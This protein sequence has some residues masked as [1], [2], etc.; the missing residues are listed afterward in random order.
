MSS[1]I[2]SIQFLENAS[3]G[4]NNW[5]RYVLTVIIS[6]IG[7]NL[8]AGLVMVLILTVYSFFL[9]SGGVTNIPNIIMEMISSPFIL[10]VL[11]GISYVLSFFFFYICLRFLHH[12]P[13]LKVINAVSSMRWGLLLKGLVLWFLI[14]GLFSLP[15]LIFNPGS[16]QVTFNPNTFSILLVLCLL[17]FPIQASFE[18][19]LFR[20]YLMQGFALFSKRLSRVFESN[21]LSK[22]WVPLLITSIA[23]GLVHFWNG[24]DLYMDMSIVSSTFIIGLMLGVIALGDNGIETAMGIHIANN[25]YVS[26]LYNSTD[27]GLPGLPSVVTAEASDPFAGI[28]ILVLAALLVIAILFWNRKDDLMRIFR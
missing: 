1:T 8:V 20:G 16:Y 7:G 11:V 25:L 24:T 22:P 4:K 14:L 3:L 19:I 5:W 15:E 28:P 23:F 17:A 12:K 26:L 9:A 27:S 21:W 13:L 6:F 18:E 2:P 10:L